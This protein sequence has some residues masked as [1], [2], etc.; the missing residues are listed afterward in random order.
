MTT[1]YVSP[2]VVTAAGIAS[3][4]WALATDNVGFGLILAGSG[5]PFAVLLAVRAR[6]SGRLPVP[7][8]F[9]GAI[10]GVIVA[11]VSY[12]LVFAFAYAFFLGFATQGTE[13]LDAL[14]V[15]PRLTTAL[16]SPWTLVLLAE[17]V[18]V[19]PVTEEFGKALG[20]RWSKPS[21]SQQ[22]LLTGVAAGTGFAVVENV[23]YA[24]GGAWAGGPWTE[25]LLAR[26]PGAAVHPLASGLVV[27]GWWEWRN[28]PRRGRSTRLILSGIGV[29]A[30]WNGSLVALTVTE[31]AF[32]VGSSMEAY[33]AVSAAYVAAMGVVAAAALWSVSGW[34][35]AAPEEDRSLRGFADGRSLGAWA[36]LSASLLIPLAM[37]LLAF[38]DFYLG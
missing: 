11:V 14:R 38:P 19:A 26:L 8:L 15:D 21:S 10:V 5:F 25:I 16:T 29:H 23:L 3:I 24:L 4:S 13:L 18:I 34:V 22:A 33:A 27:L 35:S 12:G 31:V 20:A 30:L 6:L 1:K 32:E 28:R 7:A 9:G 36:V 37:L 17:V 2:L